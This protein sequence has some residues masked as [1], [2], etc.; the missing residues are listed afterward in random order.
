[1]KNR[2]KHQ[3]TK[4]PSARAEERRARPICD[5]ALGAGAL[6]AARGRISLAGFSRGTS[7]AALGAGPQRYCHDR[8]NLP[9]KNVR[10]RR[11]VVW[12]RRQKSLLVTH[13]QEAA[14]GSDEECFQL[15]SKGGRPPILPMASSRSRDNLGPSEVTLRHLRGWPADPNCFWIRARAG[16]CS[17]ELFISQL[18]SLHSRFF[19]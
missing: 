13:C 1:M 10:L 11:N 17:R 5:A 15:F 12:F 6:K 2:K 3:G 7:M 19:W 9:L 16:A 18:L 8:P 4:D 14:V